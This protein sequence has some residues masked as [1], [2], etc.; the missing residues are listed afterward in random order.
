MMSANLVLSKDHKVCQNLLVN[1]DSLW[2]TLVVVHNVSRCNQRTI[3][4]FLSADTFLCILYKM[5][6][7]CKLVN[8]YR[9][10][11]T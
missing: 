6:M 3:E 11:I 8:N 7:C 9:D 4:L 5:S 2:G 10:S 1:V